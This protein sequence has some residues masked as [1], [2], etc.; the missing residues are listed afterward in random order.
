MND[1]HHGSVPGA[2]AGPTS[3]ALSVGISICKS[4]CVLL[5]FGHATIHLSRAQFDAFLFHALKVLAPTEDLG[6]A[7]GRAERR[8]N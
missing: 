8:R 3:A 5:Q 2:G 7:T 1:S 4:G 6:A